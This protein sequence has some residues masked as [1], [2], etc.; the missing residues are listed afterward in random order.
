VAYTVTATITNTGKVQTDEVPQLYLSHGGEG[1][2]VRVLRGFERIERIAPGQSVQFRA[3][4]TRR[5]ISNWDVVSQNWVVT[6]AE[7]T[8]WVGSSSRNLPLTAK[9]S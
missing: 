2:P 5:D 4:L 1:E 7:K 6:P 8:I 9:L 3:E